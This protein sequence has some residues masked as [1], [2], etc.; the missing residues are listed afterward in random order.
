MPLKVNF[1]KVLCHSAIFF[2]VTRVAEVGS[3]VVLGE[4]HLDTC[5]ARIIGDLVP[6][7]FTDREIL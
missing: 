5:A 4:L 3:Q 1:G 2:G 7:D 6:R